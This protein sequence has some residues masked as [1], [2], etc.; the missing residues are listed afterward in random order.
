MKKNR[1]LKKPRR[2][3]GGQPYFSIVDD[4]IYDEEY[5]AN[6]RKIVEYK[7]FLVSSFERASISYRNQT[8]SKPLSSCDNLLN[9]QV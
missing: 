2:N 3:F 7:P 4:L 1:T 9:D 8:L 5:S 6:T